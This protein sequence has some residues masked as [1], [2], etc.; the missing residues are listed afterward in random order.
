[1]RS[2][3]SRF[4]A[5][6]TYGP[7]ARCRIW[8]PTTLPVEPRAHIGR[9]PVCLKFIRIRSSAA[10]KSKTQLG[11]SGDVK[12]HFIYPVSSAGTEPSVWR[13]D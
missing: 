9:C 11:L 8:L 5:D 10:D 13:H 3:A 2:G 7:R 4:Q 12:L 6:Y 1:M